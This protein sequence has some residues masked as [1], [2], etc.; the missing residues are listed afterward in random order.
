[1]IKKALKGLNCYLWVWGQ[2]KR[3]REKMAE[4]KSDTAKNTQRL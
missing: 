3:G 1:M 2:G 4:N